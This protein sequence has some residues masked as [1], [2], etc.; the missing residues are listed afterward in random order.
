MDLSL[1]THEQM[2]EAIHSFPNAIS[3]T[4]YQG[5]QSISDATFFERLASFP[6]LKS[7][8]LCGYFLTQT[9]DVQHYFRLIP[10]LT[11]LEITF[12]YF[13]EDFGG[14]RQMFAS[15]N[16]LTSLT[17]LSAW[18]S[19]SWDSPMEVFDE[20]ENIRELRVD[21]NLFADRDGNCFF[22]SLTNLTRL[23]LKTEE[24]DNRMHTTK[25]HVPL[26]PFVRLTN[27]VVA[28]HQSVFVKS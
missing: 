22:P 28:G 27:R 15:L 4:V 17:E 23:T 12:D 25:V 26:S 8:S 11:K 24:E 10:Q 2:E 7:L 16:Y 9:G 5:E 3:L 19:P 21:F 13:T 1:D 14:S 20:L 6:N 18:R